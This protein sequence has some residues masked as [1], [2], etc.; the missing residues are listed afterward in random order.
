MDGKTDEEDFE[1]QL[2][3]WSKD[4]IDK[5]LELIEKNFSDIVNTVY[6]DRFIDKIFLDF[7]AIIKR[8][9]FIMALTEKGSGMLGALG[10]IDVNPFGDGF[11]KKGEGAWLFNPE[12]IRAI[13]KD[14]L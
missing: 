4:I 8:E 1:D 13:F 3:A 2:R 9:H 12:E 5:D 6:E 11:N 14:A 7:V 10:D